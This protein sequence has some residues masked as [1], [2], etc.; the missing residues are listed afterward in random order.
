MIA[1]MT[2]GLGLGLATGG[3]C[4]GACAPMVVPYFL[5]EAPARWKDALG[6]VLKFL[7]GRLAA[8]LVFAAAVSWMGHRFRGDIP[9]SLL[10]VA[11]VLAGILMVGYS[12]IRTFSDKAFCR[13]LSEGKSLRMWPWAMGFLV[14][15]NVCPP[16]IAGAVRLLE[17]GRV[18]S[19]ILFFLAFFVG[20]SVY[21]LP[22]MLMKPWVRTE[23][24]MNI[25][26]LAGFLSGGWFVVRGMSAWAG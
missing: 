11:S 12:G 20:T 9:L 1:L 2:E 8:Y 26:R 14:G 23:R 18:S 25:G 16:L 24:M 4:L 21:L 13:R 10:N 17:L 15:I 5:S 7:T 3:Y 22:V 6:I 19:G